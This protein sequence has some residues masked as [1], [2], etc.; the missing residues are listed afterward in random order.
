MR[1]KSRQVGPHIASMFEVD[2]NMWLKLIALGVAVFGRQ[3]R[4]CNAFQR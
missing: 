1:K 3:L 2:V 4:N